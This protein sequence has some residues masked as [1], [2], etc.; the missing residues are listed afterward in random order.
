MRENA[1]SRRVLFVGGRRRRCLGGFPLALSSCV[2]AGA[3]GVRID[4]TPSRRQSLRG[5]RR[6]L[7]LTNEQLSLRT[8][9]LMWSVLQ[10]ES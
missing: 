6:T 1:L 9:H 2:A 5:L 3:G 8:E 4:R 10:G 7:S